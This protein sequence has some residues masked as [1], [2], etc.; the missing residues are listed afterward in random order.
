M[1]AKR[2]NYL[3]SLSDGELE[4]TRTFY[5]LINDTK[6]KTIASLL[7]L[8]MSVDDY[9]YALANSPLVVETTENYIKLKDGTI[10]YKSETQEEFEARIKDAKEKSELYANSLSPE[11]KH[12]LGSIFE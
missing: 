9:K 1:F 10:V 7:N 4:A 12:Y 6:E 5:C 2:E 11:D 3:R 8:E